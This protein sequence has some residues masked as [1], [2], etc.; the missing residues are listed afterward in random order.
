MLLR[1]LSIFAVLAWLSALLSSSESS[2]KQN[3]FVAQSSNVQ[4]S[5]REAISQLLTS[6]AYAL[7]NCGELSRNC[8]LSD[9]ASQ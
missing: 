8:G 3:L 9:D 5:N 6:R 2:K 4:L 7:L 1:P